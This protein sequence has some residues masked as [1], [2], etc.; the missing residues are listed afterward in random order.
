ML[1]KFLQNARMPKGLGGSLM[2][3]FMNLGHSSL[4][5]WGLKGVAIKNGAAVLDVGCGGGKI[6]GLI[7]KK[8]PNGIVCGIDHAPLSVEKSR[9]RNHEA[10][11]N[12]KCE[13]VCGTVS[14]LPYPDR[15]FDVVTAFESVYFW[16]NLARDLAEVCR[17]MKPGGQLLI[18]NAFMHRDR[19]TKRRK[20]TARLMGLKLYPKKDFEQ[21]L[22]LAGFKNVRTVVRKNKWLRI[23]AEKSGDS[24][25]PGDDF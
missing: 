15:A 12:E 16:P 14:N 3:L 20:K 13:I 9:K 5:G 8:T 10:I 21:A 7:H 22:A 2:L 6:I 18:C 1:K 19:Q 25:Q 4:S 24:S 17:V 11:L 23:S